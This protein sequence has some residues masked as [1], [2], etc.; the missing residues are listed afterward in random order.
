MSTKVKKRPLF[1]PKIVKQAFLDSIRKLNPIHQIKNP[2][3]FVVEVG[4]VLTTLLFF[5]ALFTGK[6]EAS[7]SFIFQISLWLWITVLFANFAESM[8]EGRG[9]A[10]AESLR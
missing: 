4:S 9:K 8:A 2:V 6:G 10:Q 3:M 7:P 1:E 5:H